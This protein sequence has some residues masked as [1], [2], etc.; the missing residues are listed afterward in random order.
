[1][2]SS[3]E[4]ILKGEIFSSASVVIL[5]TTQISRLSEVVMR[6]PLQ[7]R[8]YRPVVLKI[9]PLVGRLMARQQG[10]CSSASVVSFLNRF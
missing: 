9:E 8:S 4:L 5:L 6:A 3:P 2:C 1:M 10:H 7:L